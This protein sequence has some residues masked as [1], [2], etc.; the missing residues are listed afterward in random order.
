MDKWQPTFVNNVGKWLPC[1]AFSEYYSAINMLIVNALLPVCSGNPACFHT[2][3]LFHRSM[4]SRISY[5][6]VTPTVSS[7]P[8]MLN[9]SNLHN[10]TESSGS[11]VLAHSTSGLMDCLQAHHGTADGHSESSMSGSHS[12]GSP[13][14]ECPCV[15]GNPD[16][17][18]TLMQPSESTAVEG[19]LPD[20]VD[21]HAGSHLLSDKSGNMHR[22]V[23]DCSVVIDLISHP[24]SRSSR[25]HPFVFMDGSV[26]D[27]D[28]PM[29]ES[30]DCKIHPHDVFGHSINTCL[31]SANQNASSDFCNDVDL[32]FVDDISVAGD[33][34]R[35]SPGTYPLPGHPDVS[36]NGHEECLRTADVHTCA[37]TVYHHD[38]S[39]I[40]LHNAHSHPQ[41][42]LSAC[43]PLFCCPAAVASHTVR[44]C[45][46]EKI[47]AYDCHTVNSTSCSMDSTA[48]FLSVD[49]GR[50]QNFAPIRLAPRV[51]CSPVSES[52]DIH[53]ILSQADFNKDIP[54]VLCRR[55][56][57][58]QKQ[59]NDS[60]TEQ[61]TVPPT[62][63][64]RG[65]SQMRSRS[66]SLHS[67]SDRSSSAGR[68][69]ELAH[70]SRLP[71]RSSYSSVDDSVNVDWQ[72]LKHGMDGVSVCEL[73]TEKI[74]RELRDK[75]DSR[76][77]TVLNLLPNVGLTPSHSPVFWS[78]KSC[79]SVGTY[80][81]HGAVQLISGGSEC[82]CLISSPL[83]ASAT[84][85]MSSLMSCA[86][87]LHR[88]ISQ[89][90][91]SPSQFL[92]AGFDDN[93][94]VE[95]KSTKLR[96]Q[97]HERTEEKVLSTVNCDLTVDV[98][99]PGLILTT[100]TT[101]T[102]AISPSQLFVYHHHLHNFEEFPPP[103]PPPLPSP[104]ELVLSNSDKDDDFDCL[105]PPPSEFMVDVLSGQSADASLATY[106][107]TTAS[108][109]LP[110]VAVRAV[111]ALQ[112]LAS[113]SPFAVSDLSRVSPLFM[114]HGPNNASFRP[115]CHHGD[116]EGTSG[117]VGH[118][119]GV[120][121]SDGD[122]CPTAATRVYAKDT[123][124]PSSLS[125][126]AASSNQRSFP[127]S[128][129]DCAYTVCGPEPFPLRSPQPPLHTHSVFLAKTGLNHSA[130]S[131][132]TATSSAC[133]R[134][135]CKVDAAHKR[136]S[137][138]RVLE[139]PEGFDQS[140]SEISKRASWPVE[141]AA[142]AI[143]LS[144]VRRIGL[145]AKGDQPP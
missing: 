7:K 93:G 62:Q 137:L 82:P 38:A 114:G 4:S 91:M 110:S 119:G 126:C 63:L 132:V 31:L 46:A 67:C 16:V 121:R 50:T 55:R 59:Y 95:L 136:W 30:G 79:S 105:P 103:P 140:A 18:D 111:V 47:G 53:S 112:V 58:L 27:V 101:T 41:P 131:T 106:I 116:D 1:F 107:T 80:L 139:E 102:T 20:D 10:S 70:F 124:L 104:I 88:A 133:L 109:S 22:S 5:C 98:G 143:L 44:V 77:R 6:S 125:V 145:P 49:G 2:V 25:S 97:P 13:R 122:V 83:S 48:C 71:A 57:R 128:Q 92:T 127:T 117:V 85:C 130:G 29:G 129:L 84:L 12:I 142:T 138:E 135:S 11:Q 113:S 21:S 144:H 76:G 81:Q 14:L 43:L 3:S 45:L 72:L 94:V 24:G 66:K 69:I 118:G 54:Y 134:G 34:R 36:D 19:H 73:S 90:C 65:E 56:R 86:D 141:S 17:T 26:T 33:L 120:V 100:T 75:L 39:T 40:T 108:T 61:D 9:T 74:G 96:G 60:D 15:H 123:C 115:V 42:L 28:M 52:I 87:V 99:C 32:A 51:Q 89:P 64:L 68:R 35:S 8:S 37:D 23:S 78:D